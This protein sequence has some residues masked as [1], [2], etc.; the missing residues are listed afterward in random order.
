MFKGYEAFPR[1]RPDQV[2]WELDT[3]EGP[4]KLRPG[5]SNGRFTSSDLKSAGIK[6][7]ILII[8][9]KNPK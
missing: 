6:P 3:P 5:E 8:E 4:V 9:D 1:P 7:V 2:Y